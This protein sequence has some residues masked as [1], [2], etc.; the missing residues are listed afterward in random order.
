M[1]KEI[2]TLYLNNA[3]VWHRDTPIKRCGHLHAPSVFTSH[4]VQQPDQFKAKWTPKC[5]P[6]NYV[7]QQKSGI[8]DSNRPV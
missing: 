4:T 6:K 3:P 2:C 7:T 1:I 8:R 5:V